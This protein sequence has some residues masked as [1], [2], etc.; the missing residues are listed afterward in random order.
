MKRI[1]VVWTRS[2]LCLLMLS[3]VPVR[4]VAASIKAGEAEVYE[5]KTTTVYLGDAYQR[6]LRNSRVIT[7]SW[8]SDNESYVEITW[9]TQNY[10]RIK[11]VKATAACNIRFKCSYSYDGYYRTMDFYYTVTV[12]PT[13]IE[14]TNLTMNQ[15]SLT[16][17]VG[18]TSRLGVGIWP[19]NATDKTVTWSSSAPEVVSVD[20]YGTVTGMSAGTATITARSANGKTAMCKVTCKTSV[21]KLVISDKDGLTGIPQVADIEYERTFYSGWNSVC[22]PFAFDAELL[23]L[24]DAEIAVMGWIETVGSRKYVSYRLVS[25]VEAGMPCLVYVLTDQSCKIVLDGVALVDKP[26]GNGPLSGTFIE[27]N[28]GSGCYKLASDGNSFAPTKT[29]SAVCRPFRAYIKE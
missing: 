2:I 17:G 25:Q 12:K 10:V 13:S 15:T 20:R 4:T 1:I 7:Y 21:R 6:T 14:V 22:L 26:V 11:G 3:V 27:T 18:E 9:P 24:K 19:K 29:G 5:G 16:I 28:I 23:G 8:T